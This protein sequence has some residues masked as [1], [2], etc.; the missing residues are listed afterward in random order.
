MNRLDGKIALITG[1]TQG[2]GKAIAI[3]FA[4]SGAKGIVICGRSKTKGLALAAEISEEY[5]IPVKFKESDLGNV[6]DCRRLVASTAQEFGRIDILVNSA[7]ITDRGNILDTSQELFDQM[8]AVN[9][10][11]PFFL[12]QDTVKLM[13]KEHIKGS[14]VN[15]GTMSAFAGQPFIAAYCASKGALTTLTR[16]T[17]FA[18]LRNNIRINQLNI[19]WMASDGED[20]IQKKH[21]GADDNWLEEAAKGQ[22]TG[23]LIDPQEVARAVAFLASEDSGLMTGSIVN[24]DQSVWGAFS[25]PPAPDQPMS[26]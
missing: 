15:I 9:I 16:N 7:A 20:V 17:A 4:Q 18:L 10:R 26:M 11:G 25:S 5:G 13:I 21:H 8:F 19:G 1:S 12:I 14:I 22:P 2:L 24:F 23:R 3:R 6:D